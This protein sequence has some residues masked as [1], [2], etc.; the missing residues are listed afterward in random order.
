MAVPDSLLG[1]AARRFGLLS[2]PERLRALGG[3]HDPGVIALAAPTVAAELK[4]EAS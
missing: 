2:D 3:L 1:E 4:M